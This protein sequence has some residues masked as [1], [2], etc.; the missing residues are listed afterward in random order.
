MKKSRKTG[1]VLCCFA[2]CGAAAIF[3][4]V[5]EMERTHVRPTE[6]YDAVSKQ[7]TAF[8]EADFPRAYQQVSTGFQE[9]FNLEAFAELTRTDYP[10]ILRA[11]RIE[12]G[13]VR[14]E[15]RHALVHVY[16]F[17]S[18]GDVIPCVYSLIYEESTWK[19]DGARLQKRWPPGT[20]M[21]GTRS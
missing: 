7:V 9:R 14:L 1:I 18:E 19:I 2:F 15:G 17:L 11:E 5:M 13:A 21:G 16:F 6:L 12:F 8:R 10:G 3:H 20:R 4:R